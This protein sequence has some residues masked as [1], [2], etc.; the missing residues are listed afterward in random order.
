MVVIIILKMTSRNIKS[1]TSQPVPQHMGT[2]DVN[3]P[4]TAD[5]WKLNTSWF[6]SIVTWSGI[7]ANTSTY[8]SSGKIIPGYKN[9]SLHNICLVMHSWVL[10]N[11]ENKLFDDKKVTALNRYNLTLKRILSVIK[12][13]CFVK[14]LGLIPESAYF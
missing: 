8:V 10:W 5:F 11:R 3:K 7:S 1:T 14:H 9:T 13:L 4:G 6:A 12:K 2:L